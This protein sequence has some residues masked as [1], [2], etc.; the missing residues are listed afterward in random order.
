[1]SR[2]AAL[3]FF[4]VLLTLGL[5]FWFALE[6]Q[7]FAAQLAG[8]DSAGLEKRVLPIKPTLTT[9]DPSAKGG[10]VVV[11]F[12]DEPRVRL[13]GNRLISMQSISTKEIEAVLSPYLGQRIERL[14]KSQSE[15]ALDKHKEQLEIRIKRQFADLNSYYQVEI[16]SL[17]EAERLVNDLNRLDMVEIAYY[18]PAPEPAGDIAPPTPNYKPFQGYRTAAPAGVDADYAN[19]LAGGDGTGVKI[20]DIEGGWQTTHE[21]LD[22]AVGG[23]IAGE[24]INDASWIN[25]GTAVLGEMIAGDNGYGVS[26]ICPGADV[27]MISIGTLSTADALYT[28]VANLTPGDLILIELHAPGPHYNFQSRPDQLGYVCMEYWQANFDAIQYAW[29]NGI[30]V[31]EAAG[32]GAENFDDQTL[33]AQLFDTTYRNSHAIIAGAGY[34]NTSGLDLQRQSFSNYGERVNLQ[35]Y[36]SGVYTTGY[37]DLFTGGGDQ[38]QYYT[39]GFSGT[40]SASPIVT[41]AVACLQGRYMAAYGTFLTADQIRT[42]L[43]STGTA[44]LGDLSKH[45]GPR[46]D[47]QAAIGG[48]TAPP[49]LYTSPLAIDTTVLQGAVVVRP[50]W[51]HNR[52][53]T[54]AVAFTAVGNDSLARNKMP[55]WLTVAPASGSVNPSDSLQLNVTMDASVLA[56]QIADY[57]GIVEVNWGPVPQPLDSLS[58]VP[59]FFAVL[60]N[61]TTYQALS[62][63]DLGGPTFSWIPA[64][65]IGSKLGNGS[66]YNPSLN[67]L[68]DGTAGPL[69]I[70]FAFPFFDSLYTQFWVSP[71]GAI[72]FTN[73]TLNFGGYYSST[74]VPGSP[75][76]SFLPAFWNDLIIDSAQ[77]PQAGVY[78]YRS[79]TNDTLVIEWYRLANFVN[80]DTQTDFEMVLT[81]DGKML[82]QYLNV[83]AGGLNQTA[84][85][86]LS[87][88]ECQ[89][90]SYYNNGTPA[91]NEV[92]DGIAVLLSS[93]VVQHQVMAGNVDGQGGI[94]ISDLTYLV[95]YLFFGGAAPIPMESGDLDCSGA[96]DISDLTYMVEYL[97]FGGP[98]PCSYWEVL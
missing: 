44:Q 59:V 78:I 13:K 17:A 31:I 10:M 64:L 70:G 53:T 50:V 24:M 8:T 42:A 56:Q 82:Y 30:T 72:S 29:A 28:A 1:M 49:S 79:A 33:Y 43:V 83:D 58:V 35:G 63:N 12:V 4:G 25:H 60:C 65:T 2:R 21:D 37:G 14:F 75:F 98:D 41:G 91:A 61:D 57:K 55:N 89:A 95:E 54:T 11:K 62:S 5:G 76:T 18:E 36:G 26:G 51:L 87:Q 86:G 96:V 34:P 32:N 40:S 47:L 27:G 3:A 22:K 94:D 68:D 66:F 48:F 67:P 6:S 39:S 46:P 97:F 23:L 81:S 71:N 9:I 77:V 74:S 16:Q 15:M 20:I 45:I 90:L 80:F 19:L 93:S 73:S 84:L 38:N 69:P 52:S 85:I 7:V 88:V 92:H